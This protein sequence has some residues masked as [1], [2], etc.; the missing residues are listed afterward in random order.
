MNFGSL[1]KFQ[2]DFSNAKDGISEVLK[3]PRASLQNNR[4]TLTSGLL[5]ISQ[6]LLCKTP[7]LFSY[8]DLFFKAKICGP[9]PRDDGP[10]PWVRSTGA[11]GP[12]GGA[13]LGGGF[14]GRILV[15]D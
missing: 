13:P 1:N 14:P 5:L 9:S 6:G 11:R 7:K 12:G 10:C 2:K 8:F 15:R 3:I 4:T